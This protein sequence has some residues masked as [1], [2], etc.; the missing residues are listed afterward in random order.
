[1]GAQEPVRN[2]PAAAD[3]AR[4]ALNGGVDVVVGPFLGRELLV[5]ADGAEVGADELAER[6]PTGEARARV[7]PEADGGHTVVL[8]LEAVDEGAGLG[9][10]RA[11]AGVIGDVSGDL[12]G[13]HTDGL[14][15]LGGHGP[16]GAQGLVEA[17]DLHSY[18]LG[19]RRS[20]NKRT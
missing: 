8:G 7:A 20:R 10:H 18:S 5:T 3:V 17:R 1:M 15:G 19:H 4:V 6:G 11:T 13:L 2:V 12:V 14:G 16:E 9:R